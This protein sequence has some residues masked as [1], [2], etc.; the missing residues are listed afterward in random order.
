MPERDSFKMEIERRQKHFYR[1]DCRN[2]IQNKG[3]GGR[4][5]PVIQYYALFIFSSSFFVL[6]FYN[7]SHVWKKK[8]KQFIGHNSFK[9]EVNIPYT[10]KT[11]RQAA[12]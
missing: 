9:P 8:K 1:A 2:L 4:P 5:L 3:G 10:W 12:L 7:K 11:F 6:I